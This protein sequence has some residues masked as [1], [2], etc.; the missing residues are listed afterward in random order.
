MEKTLK[1]CERLAE[2]FDFVVIATLGWEH[3]VHPPYSPGLGPR[4]YYLFL[5][6][7]R[8]FLHQCEYKWNIFPYVECAFCSTEFLN[9]GKQSNKYIDELGNYADLKIY[10]YISLC[11]QFTIILNKN[12]SHSSLGDTYFSTSSRTVNEVW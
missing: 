6:Y 2:V 3:P 9:F 10:I 11:N 5:A 1:S 7:K 12:T 8:A 4:G